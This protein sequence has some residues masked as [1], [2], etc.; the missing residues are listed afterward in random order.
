MPQFWNNS[1][2]Y[3][4]AATRGQ[5]LVQNIAAFYPPEYFWNEDESKYH[6]TF[7]V[8]RGTEFSKFYARRFHEA[9][10]M[11]PLEN[12]IITVL[13][14]LAK[15]C[16]LEVSILKMLFMYSYINLKLLSVKNYFTFVD[17]IS[18]NDLVRHNW[19]WRAST[20]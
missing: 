20:Y 2:M 18:H 3:N 11:P 17:C 1:Q 13:D 16:I 14:W 6:T 12:E 8:P 7:V 15:L 9:L 5:R 4:Y 19:I 10:G